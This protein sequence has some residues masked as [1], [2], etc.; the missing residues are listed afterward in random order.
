MAPNPKAR[1]DRDDFADANAVRARTPIPWRPDSA[2]IEISLNGSLNS[3]AM[4]RPAADGIG[5]RLQAAL[6]N[7]RSQLPVQIVQQR[8]ASALGQADGDR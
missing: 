7:G 1:P 6:E 2:S 4:C 5:S 3:A 8:A